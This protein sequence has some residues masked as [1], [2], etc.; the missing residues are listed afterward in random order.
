MVLRTWHPSFCWFNSQVSLARVPIFKVLQTHVGT[1]TEVEPDQ[2]IDGKG[3]LRTKH[4]T[5]AR[6]HPALC[7]LLDA[8]IYPVLAVSEH[9]SEVHRP[10]HGII[11]N[12]L[13][14]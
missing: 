4:L 11:V 2:T 13:K 12:D 10:I 8:L 3:C 7:E 14:L 5:D 6:I 1:S 9:V